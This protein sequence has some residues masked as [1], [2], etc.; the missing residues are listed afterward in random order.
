MK[1]L[2]KEYDVIVVGAGMIGTA[3]TIGLAKLG[4]NVLLIEKNKKRKCFLE[5]KPDVR[6][7]AISYAS[8][9]ILKEIGVWD[10]ILKTRLTPYKKIELW[11][12]NGFNLKIKANEFNLPL[13]GYIIENKI[14]Q[15]FLWKEFK[16]YSNLTFLTSSFLT[17]MKKNKNLWKV[18]INNNF[19][20]FTK[21][22]IGSDGVFSKVRSFSGIS[23]KKFYYDKMCMLIIIKSKFKKKNVIWQKF[24]SSGARAFLPLF[25]N[26]SCL[27]W[28]DSVKKI[29]FL[30][31]IS[32]F[33][34]KREVISSF[35]IQF[36]KIELYSR[37]SFSLFRHHAK[38]YVQDGLVLVGDAAHSINPIIGQGVNLGYRDIKLLLEILKKSKKYLLPF[39]LKKNL[40]SYEKRRLLNNSIIQNISDLV[41]FYFNSNRLRFVYFRNFTL[42]FLKKMKKIKKII[43]RYILGI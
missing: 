22:I 29:K 16:K 5:N 12:K 10:A 27:I 3:M 14:L 40:I 20:F 36:N 25:N 24:F 39:Y 34:L 6:V 32:K 38:N 11:E 17:K 13:L 35:P 37:K 19:Q 41:Y 21:L 18:N 23:S 33:Q 31:S 1:K 8:V 7:S 28:Y 15:E 30:E 4:W 9:K 26:W 2:I 42:F 43:F